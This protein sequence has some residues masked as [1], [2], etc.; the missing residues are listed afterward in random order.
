MIKFNDKILDAISLALKP[1][2]SLLVHE[3]TARSGKTASAI[4]SFFEAVQQSDE[5]LHCIG[6]RNKDILNNNILMDGVHGLITMFPDYCRLTEDKIGSVY[7]EI[8]CDIKDKPKI[9]KVLLVNYSDKSSWKDILSQSIGVF[10]IDEVNIANED[11]INET[12][13][14]Q[15]AV[16]NPLQIWTLNGDVPDHL[17]YQKYIN[18]CKIIGKAPAS[19]QAEMADFEKTKGWYYMHWIMSDNPIMTKEKIARAMTIYPIGSFYYITKILGERG[20]SGEL[21]FAEYM[22]PEEHIIKETEEDDKKKYT[23]AEYIV[24]LDIGATR[25]KNSMTLVGFNYQLTDVSVVDNYTFA[26]VGYD[27]KKQDILSKILEWQEKYNIRIRCIAVDSAEQNFIYDLKV[28]FAPYG[29]QVIGSYK[30]TIKERC[31]M[32]IVLLSH[33]RIKFTKQAI[34][35]FK[36]YQNAKWAEGK[37]GKEREDNNDVINDIMDSCE[38]AITVHMKD[39]LAKVRA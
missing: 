38:Y 28:L 2:V 20:S 4:I 34:A 8:Q 18:R 15:L 26:Q 11:F 24:G 33:Y 16:N 6:A 35:V 30:A 25:A 23:Y 10:L 19:I 7:V 36:A 17:I 3:G 21:I 32:L 31:D 29:I 1:Q 12:F 13:S 37:I 22:K 14:R 27:K 5:Y 9:K 39:I